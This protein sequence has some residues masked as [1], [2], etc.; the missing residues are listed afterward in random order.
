MI[1]KVALLPNEQPLPQLD[2]LAD[3]PTRRLDHIFIIL[4]SR[5]ATVSGHLLHRR[6]L[7]ASHHAFMAFFLLRCIWLWLSHD[8]NLAF[9]CVTLVN[10]NYGISSGCW[11]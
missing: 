1:T 3:S 5:N 8:T 4:P 2:F 9:A 11:A 6:L 10:T 7:L